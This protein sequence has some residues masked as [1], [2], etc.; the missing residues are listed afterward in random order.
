MKCKKCGNI[1]NENN[2]FCPICGEANVAQ[3]APVMES[4]PPTAP[5]QVAPTNKK[6]NIIIFI[7]IG[8]IIGLIIISLVVVISIKMLYDRK[9]NSSNNDYKTPITN[10]DETIDNNSNNNN[11]NN[12]NSSSNSN[13][14]VVG[15][16]KYG[17][18][19]IPNNWYKFYDVDGNNSL[20][21][22][23]ANTY[24]ITLNILD[25]QYSAKQYASN[26]MYNKKNS[27]DVTDVTGATVT[28]GKDKKYTAYQVY[29][30]YP[31]DSTYLVTYW[32]EAEDGK[33]HY[34]ALEGPKEL[35]GVKI[36]DYLDIPESFSLKSN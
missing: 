7:I 8:A 28:I 9:D 18:I 12:N 31:S 29:M 10:N 20:Q 3:T 17:Y 14:K 11:N 15:D 13:T 26:Y 21:Y 36:T 34:I 23:Y 22:S 16:E 33:V 30:Y 25:N 24:I 19:S 4:T 2:K 35:N 32:F 6:N 27:S 1:I 5:Q